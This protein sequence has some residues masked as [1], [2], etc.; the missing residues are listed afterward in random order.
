MVFTWQ[1]LEIALY[2]IHNYRSYRF[3]VALCI[4]STS[5]CL[6]LSKLPIWFYRSNNNRRV[7]CNSDFIENESFGGKNVLKCQKSANFVGKLQILSWKFVLHYLK[8]KKSNLLF[9]WRKMRS[10]PN[11]WGNFSFVSFRSQ[12]LRV[13]MGRTQIKA[14]P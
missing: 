8:D 5:I 9:L 7:F 13:L 3:S 2:F 11:E 14:H 1:N 10:G 12:L 4:I 6:G